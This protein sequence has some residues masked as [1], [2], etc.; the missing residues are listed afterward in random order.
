MQGSGSGKQLLLVQI[1]IW[2]CFRK[3]IKH[4][5]T[6]GL[7]ASPKKAH[8][9]LVKV[10]LQMVEAGTYAHWPY[11][12]MDLQNHRFT[13]SI[14]YKSTTKAVSRG[15]NGDHFIKSR[16]PQE[17]SWCHRPCL[18]GVFRPPRLTTS[19]EKPPFGT[20]WGV[21]FGDF[22]SETLKGK[23]IPTPNR[24]KFIIHA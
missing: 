2:V 15:K 5:P 18:V 23:V 6:S 9:K 17:Q 20:A 10:M 3:E 14:P 19:P 13:F 16:H 4:P 24:S 22:F 12:E 8:V 11:L 1:W 21:E 7:K